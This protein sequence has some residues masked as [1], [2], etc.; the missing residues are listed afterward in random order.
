MEEPWENSFS[1]KKDLFYGFCD[2]VDEANSLVKLFSYQTSTSYVVARCSRNFGHFE[3]GGKSLSGAFSLI[4][5]LVI[6]DCK[7]GAGGLGVSLV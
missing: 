4:T 7:R 3:L 1:W 2:T 6:G 5:R